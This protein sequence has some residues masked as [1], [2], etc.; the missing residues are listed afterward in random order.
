M[1]TK[2]VRPRVARLRLT[3]LE[4]RKLPATSAFFGMPTDL[5][6]AQGTAV[7]VPVAIGHLFDTAGNQG[8]HEADFALTY[9]PTVFTVGNTDIAL[10]TL[11]TN[12]PAS[13]TWVAA[14]STA[15]AGEVDI[16]LTSPSLGADITSVTGGVL[17][18]ITFHIRGNAPVGG[19]TIHVVVPPAISPNGASSRAIPDSGPFS[20]RG[21]HS[22]YRMV[23][24]DQVDGLVNVTATVLQ[25]IAVTPANPSISKGLTQQFTATGTFSNGSTQNLTNQV[26]WA[27]AT[28]SVATINSTGLATA[29][30]TGTSTIS[31]TLNGIT[32]STVMTV[33]S[34]ALQSIAVTP[35]NP[36]I[37]KGL[38]QQ[39]TATGTY[40]DNSTQNLTGVVTWSSATTS[41]ATISAGGLATGVA[42]GTS[43]ISAM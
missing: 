43:T 42:V 35:A 38:T 12:P 3:P 40:S 21:D 9:D 28:T 7:T 20:I 11:M 8:L 24:A 18:T 41:I 15:R 31:G 30:A 14:A 1:R 32:G 17:A 2:S 39:F 25:S 19:S 22:G 10:G 27:S 29:V 37:A 33:T 6:G 23:A 5:S 16:S 34:A 36:S 13:G 26:T 4:D